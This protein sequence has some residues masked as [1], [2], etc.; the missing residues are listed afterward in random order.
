MPSPITMHVLL[1]MEKIDLAAIRAAH[2]GT[3]S[4]AKA[5]QDQ[6][7]SLTTPRP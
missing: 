2:A 1:R 5:Q 4:T 7:L 3:A 6:R